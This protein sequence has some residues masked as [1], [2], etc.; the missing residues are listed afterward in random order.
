MIT[1]EDYIE[2]LSK[3]QDGAETVKLDRSDYNLITSL[4]R[5]TFKGTPYTNRQRDLAKSKVLTYKAQL[6]ESGFSVSDE[7]LN[8][9]RMPLR[10]IDRSRWIRRVEHINDYDKGPFIAIRF[11]FQKKLIDSLNRI[12]SRINRSLHYDKINKIQYFAYNERNVYE[13]VTAFKD[14]NFEI[15]SEVQEFFDKICEFTEENYLP[16]VYNYQ[17]KNLPKIAVTELTES[18]GEPCNDN[19]LLY[20]DRSLKY[21]L[22]VVEDNEHDD[23]YEY[24][25]AN[26]TEVLVSVDPKKLPVDKLLLTLENL[27]RTKLL[28]VVPLTSCYDTIVELQ[29]YFK[30][31]VPAN[32]V[33][34]TFRLDNVGEG[35][36]F[37]EYIKRER[38]NNKVDKNT[39]V[40]YN[41]DNKVPKPVFQ[42]KWQPDAIVVMGSDNFF[43]SRHVIHCY[44]STDLII[45]YTDH[46]FVQGYSKYMQ[47]GFYN[48]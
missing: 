19:I 1:L 14:K 22:N 27:K 46:C 31:L 25:I 40:V 10:E 16:G 5:Q 9:L 45:Y 17:I 30:N 26:R 35:V 18:L 21:G 36:E 39:K 38:I 11:S 13:I 23:S 47:R 48:I 29:Q 4:A 41:L 2:T 28:I 7:E 44:P 6:Q 34:V 32:N 37:N 42:S 43:N 8:T 24:K 33:S 3:I 20:Q 15:D 12:G